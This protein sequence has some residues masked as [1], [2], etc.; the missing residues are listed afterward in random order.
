VLK[1]Q[2]NKE[3]YMKWRTGCSQSLILTYLLMWHY[4]QYLVKACPRR[5][6]HDCLSWA[7]C[8][9][10]LTPRVTLSLFTPSA[11]LDFGLPWFLLPIWVW[12]WIQL[13]VVYQLRSRERGASGSLG[14]SVCHI[15][16]NRLATAIVCNFSIFHLE[17]LL[18]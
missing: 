17:F 3:K 16:S 18:T 8:V 6:F 1:S 14:K 15:Y 4:N 5:S 10:Y 13:F 9:Q 11:H 12:L 7:Q 2:Y